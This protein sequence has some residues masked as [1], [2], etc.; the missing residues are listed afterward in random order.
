[1]LHIPFQPSNKSDGINPV[2]LVFAKTSTIEI[3]LTFFKKP[4]GT[5]PVKDPQYPK[6]P[7]IL[8][9]LLV[10]VLN[11]FSGKDVGK[12]RKTS[13]FHQSDWDNCT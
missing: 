2:N 8:H 11:M 7:D 12:N 3:T 4:L 10:P 1:M 6:I 13:I 5:V 9:P